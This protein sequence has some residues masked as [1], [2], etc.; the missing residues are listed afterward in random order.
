MDRIHDVPIV[1]NQLEPCYKELEKFVHPG[2]E[3][4]KKDLLTQ[5]AYKTS[6]YLYNCIKNYVQYVVGRKVNGEIYF[7]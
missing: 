2:E 4:P 5:L 6:Y 7:Y 1:L 3:I